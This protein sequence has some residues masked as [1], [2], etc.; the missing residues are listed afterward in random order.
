MNLNRVEKKLIMFFGSIGC[1]VLDVHESWEFMDR[2]YRTASQE[3]YFRFHSLDFMGC[4][5]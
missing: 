3:K 1:H 2:I 4:H 5:K